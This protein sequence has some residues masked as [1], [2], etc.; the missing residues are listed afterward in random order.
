L[1]EAL[2]RILSGRLPIGETY[3]WIDPLCI[4]Q[5][6]YQERSQ[7]V[8]IMGDIFQEASIVIA[9]LGSAS[10]DSKLAMDYIN[11]FPKA[12]YGDHINDVVPVPL[13]VHEA[14]IRFC[15]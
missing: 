12:A 8:Q 14:L 4:N 2:Q 10:E 9:W 13:E 6:D 5:D 3:F 7:Q 11:T 15:T 1:F